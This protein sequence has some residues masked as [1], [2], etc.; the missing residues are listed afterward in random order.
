MI[1]TKTLEK[2]T[3][4]VLLKV[5]MNVSEIAINYTISTVWSIIGEKNLLLKYS[6][7]KFSS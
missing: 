6:L 4:I 7:K 1:F 5:G 3:A 2:V